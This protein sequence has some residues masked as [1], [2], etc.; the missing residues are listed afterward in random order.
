MYFRSHNG[1]SFI[2]P[3]PAL[4]WYVAFCE[5]NV[6]LRQCEGPGGADQRGRNRHRHREFRQLARGRAAPGF[7]R[8]RGGAG[9]VLA[10]RAGTVQ[11]RPARSDGGRQL[12]RRHRKGREDFPAGTGPDRR[13][14]G[15][16]GHL[17]RTVRRLGVHA[18]RPGRYRLARGGAAPRR[19]RHGRAAGPVLA[20][21]GGRELRRAVRGQRGRQLRCRHP[22]GRHGLPD[23]VRPDRRRSGGPRHLE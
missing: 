7:Q 6:H 2:R 4:N 12:R 21:A 8:Q 17:E 5:I 11:Q 22:A 3:K 20:A 9:A 10:L 16:A 23:A 13:R 19:Y 15:G 14:R 1:L 18:E